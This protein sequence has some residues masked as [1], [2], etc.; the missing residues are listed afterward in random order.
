MNLLAPEEMAK[1]IKA[2]KD[3]NPNGFVVVFPHWG[4][5]YAWKSRSKTDLAKK[6]VDADADIVIGHSSNFIQEIEKYKDKWVIY[7]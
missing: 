1:S 5:N 4:S 6:L 3:K 2:F 7:S